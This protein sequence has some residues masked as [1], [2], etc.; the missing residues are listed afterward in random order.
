MKLTGLFVGV[1]ALTLSAQAG[2]SGTSNKV[3][4]VLKANSSSSGMTTSS[5]QVS[6]LNAFAQELQSQQMKVQSTLKA[7]NSV[8]VEIKN[9]QDL[10][11]LRNNPLVAF[12]DQDIMFPAPKPIYGVFNYNHSTQ[13]SARSLAAFGPTLGTPWGI[14]AIHSHE[15]WKVSQSGKGAR[16][17]ILDTGMDKDHPALAANL[18]KGQD[19]VHDGNT[20]Y[21]FADKVGHGTHVSGTIAGVLDSNGFSGVAPQ[22]KLLMGRVCSE[23]GCSSIAIAEGLNWGVEQKVDAI[24]MSL[25]GA[26]SPP[27]IR[28]AIQRAEDQGI[29][30]VAAAGNDGTAIVGYPAA[31]DTVI[32]V[33]AVDSHLTRAKFSQYGPELDIC[34]PGV[35]VL[36]SL[37][38]GSGRESVIVVK[39]KSGRQVNLLNAPVQG[40]GEFVGTLEGD[41]V[42][43]GIGQPDDFKN[44]DVKGKVALM[45]RGTIPFTDKVINAMHAGAIAVIIHNNE[46]GLVRGGIQPPEPVNI[47]VFLIEQQPGLD[48]IKALNAG[49]SIHTQMSIQATDYGSLDGTSM[50]TPHVAGVVALIKASNKALTPA[51]VRD[52]IKK[53]AAPMAVNANNECGAGLID[54]ASA[55]SAAR[56]ARL[57]SLR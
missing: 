34:A 10:E 45:G 6:A 56:S 52:I 48:M 2:S 21:E 54:A 24:S 3:L 30:V 22:A 39:D 51:Q 38:L 16:I 17:L 35:E 46:P 20:P 12:V 44:V 42:A 49:Q 57:P 26:M 31:L 50:A 37:P 8:V 4:V 15:A 55:V 53:T 33:G 36:S 18:E 14:N 29:V 47:P 43:T 7:L 41:F 28:M 11:T 19:F 27:S 5:A 40:A 23:E 25:G 1:L 9:P 32:A 13:A